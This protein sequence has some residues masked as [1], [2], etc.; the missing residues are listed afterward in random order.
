[1]TTEDAWR[2]HRNEI[3][4]ARR[5]HLYYTDPVYRLTKLKDN[6]ERRARAKRKREQSCQ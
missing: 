4:A 3:R 1:M 5:K 6:R 2:M